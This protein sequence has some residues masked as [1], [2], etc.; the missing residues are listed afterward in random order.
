MRAL[1]FVSSTVTCLALGAGL[2]TLSCG[3][4]STDQGGSGASA[5]TDAGGAGNAT[6]TGGSSAAA[7]GAGGA[8]GTSGAGG[9]V[10]GESGGSGASAG[11]SGASGA[12][13]GMGATGGGAT[14]G[15]A[16]SMPDAGNGAGGDAMAGSGAGGS[17]GQA[18]GGDAGTSA[19]GGAAG[20]G[21]GL[22]GATP[23][24]GC[25]MAAPATGPRSIDVGGAM[26]DY[27]LRLP[28]GYD[29]AVPHRIIFAFHGGSGSAVQVDNGDPANT[30]SDPTGPY[31]D[32]MDE[33]VD[34]I[35]VA[36]QADGTWDTS[37]SKDVNYVK[38]I[39]AELESTLCI[40]TSRIFATGFSMGALMTIN[41]VGCK[42]ADVFR[43]IA[44]MSG[45]LTT[46]PGDAAIPYWSSHG[47]SD[48]TIDISR[49]EEARD[50][51]VSRNGC[52]DTTVASTPPGCVT[53]QGCNEG[54]PVSFCP[55]DGVHQPPPFSGPAIW[56]FFSQF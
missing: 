37:S 8:S 27:I 48:T 43:A 15:S 30:A 47:T 17:A 12:A 44:P 45:A 28:D 52:D 34:T 13:A 54:Y 19:A 20:G 16:G 51:F 53:Y 55:F 42:M 46:C 41:N 29:P 35:F 11:V 3:D 24:D 9:T 22:P 1:T 25:N 32:I 21:G 10:M 5:G 40:D 36:G 6:G 49:G 56:A 18:S 50:E 4:S 14:G 33:S 26:R 38:A 39:V 23:S 7:S 31:Y 2:A